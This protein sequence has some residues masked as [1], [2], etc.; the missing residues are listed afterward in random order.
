MLQTAVIAKRTDDGQP[1]TEE[2]RGLTEAAGARVVGEVTQRRPEDPGTQFGTGKVAELADIVGETGADTVVVDNELT[3]NQTVNL[4][5]E[6]GVRVVDRH[7]V[8]LEIFAQQARTRRAQLQV[9]LARLRYR[10]PRL[11]EEEDVQFLNRLLEKGTRQDDVRDRI[12]EIERKLDELPAVDEKHR[13]ARRE[14]GFDL[15]AIAGYTNAGKSTLLRRLADDMRLEELDHEDLETTAGVEDR[16]FKTLETTTRRATLRGRE[17]LLTDTVGFLDDLPHWLVESFRG[18]LREVEEADAVLLVADVAQPV[19]ELRRKL[20][21]T[22]E[23]LGDDHPPVVAALNK[24][25]AVEERAL[26]RKREAVADVAP[27]PVALSAL[28]GRAFAESTGERASDGP[29]LGDDLSP[30]V[31]QVVGALPDLAREELELPLADDAMS[32]VSWLHDEAARVDVEYGSDVV[33]VEVAA[34]PATLAKTRA[35]AEALP[36]D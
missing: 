22:M 29:E 19:E 30:L 13:E 6:T 18:T 26:A 31:D 12:D 33:Q 2:I 9:E 28:E 17:V 11:E 4:Q 34:R 7:R 21:T 24:A 32:L 14:Q 27:N 10:L 1:G 25:D 8:V 36:D 3:P 20:E 23:T 35:R 15:V 16:L 5:R